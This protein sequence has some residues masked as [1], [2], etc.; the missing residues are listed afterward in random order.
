MCLVCYFAAKKK[1]SGALIIQWSKGQSFYHLSLFRILNS[2]PNN[3]W[4]IEWT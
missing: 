1:K 2:A 3:I 4:R